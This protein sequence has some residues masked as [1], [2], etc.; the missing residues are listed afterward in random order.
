MSNRTLHARI[1]KAVSAFRAGEL[2]IAELNN[3]VV[4]NGRALESMPF[5]LSK[6][7]GD[8]DYDLTMAR[9]AEE[10]GCVADTDSALSKLETWLEA[11][12]LEVAGT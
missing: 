4:L 11:V 5:T 10:E 7:L 6:D 2:T 1:V 3:A 8:I 9:L 12:P